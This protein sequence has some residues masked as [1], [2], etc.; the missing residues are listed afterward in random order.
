MEEFSQEYPVDLVYLW[1]DGSD[2]SWQKEKQFLQNKEGLLDVQSNN[3]CRYYDNDEL[4]YS[5]RSAEKYVPWLRKIF[6]VT[7]GQVPEWLNVNHSKIQLVF[8]KEFIP[9]KY[10]PT[11]NSSAIECFLPEIPDLSEHFLYANDDMFFNCMQEKT[12]FFNE[13]GYPIVR[14]KNIRK[15][16][17]LADSDSMYSRRIG[18]VNDKINNCFGKNYRYFSHHNVDAY[19]K[20]EFIDCKERFKDEFLQTAKHRFRKEN[21]IER[22]IVNLY[23]CANLHGEIKVVHRRDSKLPLWKKIMNFLLQKSQSDSVAFNLVS[24]NKD[25]K[26]R[27]KQYN[28]KLFCFNDCEN[29]LDVDRRIAHKY[30]D[31]LFPEK[32]SFE[33]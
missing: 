14:V 21:D 22:F 11:Y 29:T 31:N 16:K 27:M 15:K 24:K 4:K 18:I 20:S 12:F 32:S 26:S 8:H 5:L 33:R 2:E 9:E 19:L 30:L 6:I 3:E 17:I 23:Q 28:P 13:Q 7:C 10:L 1:V 25:L